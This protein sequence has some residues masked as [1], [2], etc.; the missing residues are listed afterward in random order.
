MNSLNLTF[1]ADCEIYARV[2]LAALQFDVVRYELD[3]EQLIL[4][5][6]NVR[7]LPDVVVRVQTAGR[8][9]ARECC[10][11]A[12][13]IPE[14]DVIAR[15]LAP[16]AEYTGMEAG[17]T[18]LPVPDK[19]HIQACIDGLHAKLPLCK[20]VISAAILTFSSMLNGSNVS[21]LPARRIC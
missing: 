19:E 13:L 12:S 21:R 16:S 3:V 6:G 2:F 10:W 7:F 8:L 4:P 1:R 9:T 5:D 17:I 18:P 15:T 20:P 11:I 14:C